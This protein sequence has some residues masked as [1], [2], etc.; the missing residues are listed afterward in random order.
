MAAKKI[1]G[2]ALF[3]PRAVFFEAKRIFEENGSPKGGEEVLRLLT[4]SADGGDAWGLEALASICLSGKIA[5]PDGKEKW[6]A[7]QD[8]PK[9][10]DC[11][12]RLTALSWD[13]P[14]TPKSPNA[15]WSLPDAPET[16]LARMYRNGEGV[17]K[18]TE[19]GVRLLHLATVG[20]GAEVSAMKNLADMYLTG[21]DGIPKDLERAAYWTLKWD[22]HCDPPSCGEGDLGKH[23]LRKSDARMPDFGHGGIQEIRNRGP[24][25]FMR[26]LSAYL[27]DERDMQWLKWRQSAD[28]YNDWYH[29]GNIPEGEPGRGPNPYEAIRKDKALAEKYIAKLRKTGK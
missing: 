24:E 3:A 17:E 12:E 21:A 13:D 25:A 5:Q 26:G 18:D 20:L 7:P 28:Y 4:L 15:P 2:A 11:L 22:V 27:D 29:R 16:I 8:F 14:W 9:A 10:A 19:R 1:S 23:L 6:S